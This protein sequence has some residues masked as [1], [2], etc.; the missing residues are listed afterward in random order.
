[1]PFFSKK[2]K[3]PALPEPDKGVSYT[4]DEN[5]EIVQKFGYRLPEEEE[6]PYRFRWQ[7]EVDRRMK[8]SVAIDVENENVC[9]PASVAANEAFREVGHFRKR[10]TNVTL[11]TYA[12][13]IDAV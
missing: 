12:G 11:I 6:E 2:G 9:T 7:E 1:M 10:V 5:G 3:E 8:I 13:P 4:R